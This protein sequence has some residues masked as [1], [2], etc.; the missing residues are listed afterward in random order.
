MWTVT[1]NPLPNSTSL[2]IRCQ[3]G[4][5]QL[6]F[7]E[8]VRA[9]GEE[10]E[11]RNAF[12]QAL[13]SLPFEAFRWETPPVTANR[14]DR[15]FECIVHNSPDLIRPA[16]PDDFSTYLDS[17]S[18]AV[19]F[20]NLGAD[21]LLVAPCPISASANYSHL[22]AFHRSAPSE[23]QHGLWTRVADAVRARLGPQPFW[24]NTA[25]GGVDWLHVRL[26][27]KPKYYRYSPWRHV[28]ANDA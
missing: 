8:F 1:T 22:G 9:L 14:L 16:N 26:D 11:F 15:P 19:S 25:G 28:P 18:L 13:R 10:A 17:K 5:T 12:L 20:P 4:L 23:Q 3:R 6:C 21:A 2:H 27:S 24:L 7:L